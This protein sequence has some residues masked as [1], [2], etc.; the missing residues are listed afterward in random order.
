MALMS[1]LVENLIDSCKEKDLFLLFFQ[2]GKYQDVSAHFDWIQ[3]QKLAPSSYK[4]LL[5]RS[6]K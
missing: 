3:K 6:L 2:R 1:D 4:S 5:I